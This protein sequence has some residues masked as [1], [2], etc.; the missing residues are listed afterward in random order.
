MHHL[1]LRSS[2]VSVLLLMLAAS[3]APVQGLEVRALTLHSGSS[4]VCPPL[5]LY[6]VGGAPVPVA[7][8]APG[9]SSTTLIGTPLGLKGTMTLS[10][11]AGCSGATAGSFAVHVGM[12]LLTMPAP[13]TTS[14]SQQGVAM[15]VL[16]ITTVLTATGTFAQDPAHSGSPMYVL[17]SGQVVYGRLTAP[18]VGACRRMNG[19]QQIACIDEQN[20][21]TSARMVV[22]GTST[23]SSVTGYLLVDSTQP[24][25]LGLTFLPPPVGN[26][27]PV[28]ANTT[29]QAIT[30]WGTRVAS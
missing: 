28:R 8:P 20:C 26:G 23:F 24:T 30:L 13:P 2:T 25:S 19:R 29:M 7:T 18:C 6:A 16:A 4:A 11:Y 27:T 10:G 5:A 22:T 14:G 17:V 12:P 15:P 1:T 21:P 3:M 9:V